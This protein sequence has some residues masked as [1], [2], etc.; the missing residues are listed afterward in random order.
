MI[1]HKG[2]SVNPGRQESP[3]AH[4]IT[5]DPANQ[6]AMVADL[7]LDKVMIYRLKPEGGILEKNDPA[8]ADLPPGSGPRHVA[9]DP[10]GRHLYVINELNCTVVAFRY[11]AAKGKLE[12]F[13]TIP[14]L[15]VEQKPSDSTAEIEVHPSGKFL[16]GS[17]RGPTHRRLQD[18][19]RDRSIDV[20]GAQ[21]HGRKT[22]R[23][24]G[25]DPTGQYLLATKRSTPRRIQ[26]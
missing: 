18:R 2:T 3:H 24:F 17:N 15:P 19:A 21:A 1:Q 25:I 10:T 4:C 7:G 12:M 20:G 11:D 22:P 9:F 26:N 8:S 23:N 14:T 16:Y 6:L 5:L 13:Q